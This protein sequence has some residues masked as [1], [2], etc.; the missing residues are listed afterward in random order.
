MERMRIAVA[1]FGA[2]GRK[3]AEVLRS[4]AACERVV[5]VEPGAPG[6]TQA[7]GMGFDV[8]PDIPAA[9]RAGGLGAAVIATPTSD[10]LETASQCIERCLPILVEK[11]LADGV[12]A[13]NL[14]TGRA[15]AAGVPLLVGHH[16]RHSPV[17]RMAAELIGDGL[18]GQPTVATVLYTVRKP[19]AYFDIPWHVEPEGGGPI[20]INLI[21]E[22]DQLRFLYGD[23]TSVQAMQSH[24]VRRLPVE[25]SAVVLLGFASGAVGTIT[26]SDCVA[27]PWSYDLASG[28]FDLMSGKAGLVDRGRDDTH[29]L[30]GTQGS[31][32]LP[33]LRHYRF[34]GEQ[35]WAHPLAVR[36]VPFE[37]GD[38]YRHQAEH[39]LRVAQGLE[40]PLV[41]GADATRTLEVTQAIKRA[42]KTGQAIPV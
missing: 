31:L 5:I 27:A 29:F 26:L 23:I 4:C 21:H 24:A 6:R 8:Y 7:Q 41:T 40:A 13:A 18:I 39:F 28:E 19:D 14:L 9:W 12:E 16:R 35:G 33:N 22:V 11:P 36:Q 15:A 38:P 2:I 17:V 25:D 42:A 37:P 20:L 10:H 32:T 34:S 3:H 30:S 1:G